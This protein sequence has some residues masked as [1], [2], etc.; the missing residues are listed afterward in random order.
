[1]SEV[2]FRDL[3]DINRNLTG[4]K[5]KKGEVVP[6]GKYYQ[7]VIV[8]IVNDKDEILLQ[9]RSATKGGKWAAT[10]GHPKS[11]ENSLQGMVAEIEEELG[12]KVLEEELLLFKTI[13]SNDDFL[14]LYYLKKNIS[15]NDFV[16]QEEE[17]SDVKWFLKS[18]IDL[19][20]K[21]GDFFKYNID[22]YKL[23]IEFLDKIASN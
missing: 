22:E 9:K 1:M 19:M 13:V 8:F 20:I 18:K 16:L 21:A 10:G 4:E 3:Y 6:F 7:T 2:E 17:V 23:F 5:V 15:A 12:I 11:G 14:D